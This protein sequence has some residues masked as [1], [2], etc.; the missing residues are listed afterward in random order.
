MQDLSVFLHDPYNQEMWDKYRRGDLGVWWESTGFVEDAGGFSGE[1]T[2][3]ERACG[4]VETAGVLDGGGFGCF[5]HHDILDAA[6]YAL[7]TFRH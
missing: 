1:G 7:T 2:E 3:Y 6:R 4:W 5:F